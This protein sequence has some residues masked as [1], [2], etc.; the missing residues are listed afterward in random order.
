M[1]FKDPDNNN[2]LEYIEAV[3]V[4]L[5]STLSSGCQYYVSLRMA[6]DNL[7]I[8]DGAKLRLHFTKWGE[9]W[10]SNNSDNIR[11]KDF[12][13]FT[14][15]AGLPNLWY[16]FQTLVT[17]TTNGEL[18]NLVLEPHYQNKAGWIVVDD[19]VVHPCCPF[20]SILQ[21]PVDI[22]LVVDFDAVLSVSVTEPQYATF[23]WRKLTPTP[24]NLTDGPDYVGTTT[25]MLTIIAADLADLG[26]YDCVITYPCGDPIV[27]VPARLLPPCAEPPRSMVGWYMFDEAGL[28][29]TEVNAAGG[30]LGKKFGT[31]VGPSRIFGEFVGD[32][33]G[34]TAFAK[35]ETRALDSSEF[36]FGTGDFSID[37]WARSVASP[38]YSPFVDKLEPTSLGAVGYR[39]YLNANYLGLTLADTS[40][41]GE[42]DFLSSN[43]SAAAAVND[44][45]W[46]H[47]AATVKRIGANRE[48]VLYQDGEPIA[49]FNPSGKLGSVS[50]GF[51]L[52]IGHI[53][54]ISAPEAWSN[55]YLDEVELFRR[56]LTEDEVRS[57]YTARESGK[58]KESCHVSFWPWFSPSGGQ[59]VSLMLCN[60]SSIDQSYT[61]TISGEAATGNCNVPGSSVTYNPTSNPS[62]IPVLVPAGKCVSVPIG[63]NN[64]L[65][66]C[67]DRACFKVTITNVTTGHTHDCAGSV[68]RPCFILAGPVGGDVHALGIPGVGGMFSSGFVATYLS[69]PASLL[70]YEIKAIDHH[71]GLASES[72]SL[73]GQA[74]GTAVIGQV[75]LS[76]GPQ[77]IP[78]SGQ[79]VDYDAFTVFDLTLFGDADGDGIKEV[80]AVIPL[81]SNPAP[82]CNSNGIPDAEEVTAGSVPDCDGNGVPDSCDIAG[83]FDCNGNGIP[84]A[85]DIAGGSEQDCNSNGIPDDCDVANGTSYDSDGDGMLDECDGCPLDPLKLAPGA[86]GCGIPD[87]DTDGDG[88]LDCNDNCDALPNPGQADCDND[89]VGDVCEIAAGTQLDLNGNGIPDECE[90]QTLFCF[91]DGTGT[92]C[93]CAN[94]S[95]NGAFEGCVHSQ[96]LAGRL[97]ATGSSSLSNDTL[98]LT[99]SQL[100]NGV[101]IF[102]QGTSRQNGGAGV[103]FGDGLRC[104]G[105]SLIRIGS[106][107]SNGGV[108]QIPEAGDFA[109]SV[110]GLVTSPGTRTYQYW[111][112]NSAAFCTPATFNLTNGVEIV[113]SP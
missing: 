48:V 109:V 45:Q 104:V 5:N 64:S 4:G 55:G 43:N 16:D 110:R 88:I 68:T 22:S 28:G 9:H 70:D 77:T 58:C 42:T 39:L 95:A 24:V 8:A 52:R 49:Q 40:F 27:S 31:P 25:S 98:V 56:A 38:G 57:I 67:S 6:V 37:L 91:G 2:E 111:F 19:V 51:P 15:A 106:K 107:V 108:A 36:N 3:R 46:H 60:Y 50:N 20:G 73:N 101:G 62:G 93:P 87:T 7:D 99:A 34:F 71:T 33:L 89:G 97:R 65:L 10:K 30:K 54:G 100:P 84:D 74:A 96:G 47:F 53:L 69:G 75:N 21:Q 17:P 86:C 103:V 90:S 1:N 102:L 94:S 92:S 72:I 61:W 23:Q 29:L 44:G 79:F 14:V 59:K 13:N 105:G 32:C 41:L 26:S 81:M 113:W 12:T 35:Q 85:C 112:R 83:G 80:L 63:V 76:S 66:G 78:I 11:M 18:A 82:D